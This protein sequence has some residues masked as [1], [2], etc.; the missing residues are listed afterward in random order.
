MVGVGDAGRRC[1]LG[2]DLDTGEP[3]VLQY[4]A[5]RNLIEDPYIRGVGA[6]ILGAG[7]H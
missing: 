2:G 5:T 3:P 6:G 1:L 7:L 4:T